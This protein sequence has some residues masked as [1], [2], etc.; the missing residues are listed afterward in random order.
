MTWEWTRFFYHYQVLLSVLQVTIMFDSSIK[1]FLSSLEKFCYTHYKVII[2][3]LNYLLFSYT[4][5][6]FGVY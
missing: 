1:F 2:N 5:M 3:I 6:A 4:V